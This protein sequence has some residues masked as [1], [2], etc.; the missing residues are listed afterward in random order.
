M[1]EITF[2]FH[3]KKLGLSLRGQLN[4]FTGGFFRNIYHQ[5]LYGFQSFAV[6]ALFEEHL[7]LTHLKLV[8]FAA[9]G[10][11]QYRQVEDPPAKYQELIF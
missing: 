3:D 7:G 6:L 4:H 5:G 9:H 8:A 1:L 11:N 10:F 2:R